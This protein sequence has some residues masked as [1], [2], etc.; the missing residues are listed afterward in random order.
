MI[1]LIILSTDFLFSN[2]GRHPNH[3]SWADCLRV[4][5]VWIKQSFM[6]RHKLLWF[7]LSNF[8]HEFQSYDEGST[9]A[10]GSVYLKAVGANLFFK[11]VGAGYLTGESG[12]HPGSIRQNPRLFLDCCSQAAQN[13]YR[14][15][16]RVRTKL[17]CIAGAYARVNQP[18]ARKQQK[19]RRVKTDGEQKQLLNCWTVMCSM[20]YL[21]V[22]I[23]YAFAIS[24]AGCC[25]WRFNRLWDN[26]GN[27]AFLRFSH[28]VSSGPEKGFFQ[29]WWIIVFRGGT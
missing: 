27:S 1:H 14:T 6:G 20:S 16:R 25:R 21:G 18:D 3:N 9:S 2:A 5:W 15:L 22:R 12:A 19:L 29:L 13:S 8:N 24:K 26:E 10:N 23:I 17:C 28:F 11:C 4:R 7:F